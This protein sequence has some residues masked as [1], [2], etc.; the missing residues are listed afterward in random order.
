MCVCVCELG[1]SFSDHGS[2][3]R[4]LLGTLCAC[5]CDTTE[6][7]VQLLLSRVQW[8]GLQDEVSFSSNQEQRYSPLCRSP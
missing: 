4:C 3:K 2:W 1:F 6:G 5:G 7:E 8:R